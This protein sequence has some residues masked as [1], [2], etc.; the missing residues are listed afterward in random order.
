MT[1]TKRR[2]VRFAALALAGGLAIT[3]CGSDGEEDSSSG[4]GDSSGGGEIVISGSSTVEPITALVAEMFSEENDVSISV[5]G[6]GTGDGFELFCQGETDISDA[7]RPIK[8]EE[9]ATCEDN[10]IEYTELKVAIDGLSVVTST[11]NDAVT[12]LSFGDVYSLLGPESEGFEKWSAANSLAAELNGQYGASQG[13]FPDAELVITAPGEESGTYDS[14]VEIVIEKIAE[15]RGKEAVTRKDYTSSPND[16]VII[17][18]VQGSDTSLGWVGYAFVVENSDKVK[19]LEVDGGEGCVRPT[20]ETVAD[21]TYPISR[22][23]FIYVNNEKAKN[24]ADLVSFVDFYLSD[25]GL[26]SVPEVGYVSLTDEAI[27]STRSTWEGI[28]S[29]I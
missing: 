16:N 23:L 8:D 11:N 29:Q 18:G 6:P 12:C 21:G 26:A 25:E 3:A 17:E 13:P 10:G 19:A 28:T 7:S 27:E 15:A 4:S 22:D 14:F 5:D 1:Q 24:N 2:F 9:K 20:E